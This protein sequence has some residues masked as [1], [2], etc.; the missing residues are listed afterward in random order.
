M[1]ITIQRLDGTLAKEF[2]DKWR[3]ALLSQICVH[4]HMSASAL[5]HAVAARDQVIDDRDGDQDG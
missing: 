2:T 5:L 1:Q 3:L 4:S